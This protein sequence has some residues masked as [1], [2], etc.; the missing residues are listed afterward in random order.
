MLRVTV[1]RPVCLSVK[2]PAGAQEQIFISVRQ[3]CVCWCGAPFLT[4]GRVCR[5]QLL[6]ALA[7]AVILGSESG[8]NLDQILLSQIRGVPNLEGQVPVFISPRNSVT[9]L[10]P[11]APGSLFVASYDSQGYGGVIRSHLH[12]GTTSP[13]YIGPHRKRLFHYCVFSRCRG[14]NV[15]T[16]LF[17]SNGCCAVACLH[18]CYLAKGL[19]VTTYANVCGSC[20]VVRICSSCRTADWAKRGA[21]SQWLLNLDWRHFDNVLHFVTDVSKWSQYSSAFYATVIISVMC[22]DQLC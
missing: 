11:E 9:Q 7:S 13:R 6:L 17:P 12:K 19:H 16:E 18:S 8:E 21:L 3:L 20:T 1:S 5:L 4:R 10:Y 2:P 15:S 22:N 14:N